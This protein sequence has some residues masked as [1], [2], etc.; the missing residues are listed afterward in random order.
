M[1]AN[2]SSE[3]IRAILF[4]ATEDE[5]IASRNLCYLSNQL[6]MIKIQ[7]RVEDLQNQLEQQQGHNPNIISQIAG[8]KKDLVE[9]VEKTIQMAFQNRETI[10]PITGLIYAPAPIKKLSEH[11]PKVEYWTHEDYVK[12]TL[13]SVNK[14]TMNNGNAT[15]KAKVGRPRKAQDPSENPVRH[16]YLQKADGSTL[17]DTE[18]SDISKSARSIWMALLKRGLAPP[19]YGTMDVMTKLY[20]VREMLNLYEVF[21]LADSIWKLDLWASTAY[22]SW[23]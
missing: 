19:S 8:L 20:F 13:N 17:S 1:P 14:S 15:Q 5:M 3:A 23:K 10:D 16:P 2:L 9:L 6:A 4:S 18:L 12:A 11:Y 7:K 21:Q 22:P